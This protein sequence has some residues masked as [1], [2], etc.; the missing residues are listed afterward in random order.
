MNCR[1]CNHTISGKYCSH[2]GSPAVLKRVDGSYIFHELQHILHFEKGILYTIKALLQKPGQN[3]RAF[4]T[5]DRARLVKPIIFIIITSVIYTAISHFH[6]VEMKPAGVAAHTAT[7]TIM[8]WIE[9]HYGYANIIMGIF[10][11]YWLKLLFLKSRYNIFEILI[12]L[13][14]VMGIGMLIFAIFAVVDALLHINSHMVATGAIMAY[15]TWAIG[16]FFNEKKVLSYV[17]AFIG[18]SVG[19]LS[20]WTVAVLTGIIIDKL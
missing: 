10:I 19:M 14:F 6:G 11:G 9:A 18:Y 17:L 2:C 13:C 12:M 8:A 15:C 3:I 20:F 4:I 1:N 16:Q 7:V 5:E